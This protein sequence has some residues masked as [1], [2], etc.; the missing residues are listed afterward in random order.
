M[1]KTITILETEYNLM[2]RKIREF[3]DQLQNEEN[4]MPEEIVAYE[5]LVD[6]GIKR[7]WKHGDEGYG[8]NSPKWWRELPQGHNLKMVRQAKYK[9]VK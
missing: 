9:K 3:E 4:P 6:T 5:Y 2:K 7:D 1:G 8:R